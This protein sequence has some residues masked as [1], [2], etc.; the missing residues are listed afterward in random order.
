MLLAQDEKT[1]YWT[2]LVD[3]EGEQ[4][5][6]FLIIH[7]EKECK[8]R[9]CDIHNRR[10]GGV[11]ASWPLNWRSDKGSMEVICPC[12]T[13][14]PTPAYRDFLQRDGLAHTTLIHGCCGCCAD[15]ESEELDSEDISAQVHWLA[16]MY[17]GR[18]AY[19]SKHW[20]R[21][22]TTISNILN[23]LGEDEHGDD[24]LH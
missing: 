12:G 11:Q 9:L 5:G 15:Y 13:G 8:D 22:Y 18:E 7:S 6:V 21:A 17:S 10:G 24:K 1:G 20:D 23:N 3:S 14:H 16:Q 4:Y 19:T 2:R